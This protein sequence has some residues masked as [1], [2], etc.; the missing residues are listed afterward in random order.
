MSAT[1]LRAHNGIH[2]FHVQPCVRACVC[3]CVCMRAGRRSTL[4]FLCSVHVRTYLP[5][6]LSPQWSSTKRVLGHCCAT[7]DDD[8]DDDDDDN[9]ND[10]HDDD[11]DH[12][13]LHEVSI[14]AH[15]EQSTLIR[16]LHAHTQ[17]VNAPLSPK[18]VVRRGRTTRNGGLR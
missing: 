8:D 18:A 14:T 2:Q 4:R 6:S 11:D 5:V 7:Y 15:N 9:D 16:T 10:D 3:L 17:F 1:F 13:D 12:D